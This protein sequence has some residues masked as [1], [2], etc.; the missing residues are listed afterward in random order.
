MMMMNK[1]L[2]MKWLV[3]ISCLSGTMK[4]KK[5]EKRKSQMNLKTPIKL[6]DSFEDAYN[7]VKGRAR[8]D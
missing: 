6:R 2:K 7:I 3:V 1:I 5:P 8:R 4:V